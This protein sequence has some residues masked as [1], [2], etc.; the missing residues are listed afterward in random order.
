MR[1]AKFLTKSDTK[2]RVGVVEGDRL[3]PL[4]AGDSLLSELLHSEDVEGRILEELSRGGP[5]LPL[6]S[7]RLL[8]AARCAGGLGC[9]RDV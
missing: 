1:I 9:G 2:P 3:R 7:V 8:R 6:E 5:D 4:G